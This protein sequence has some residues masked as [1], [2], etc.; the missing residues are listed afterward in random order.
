MGNN[1]SNAWYVLY[2]NPTRVISLANISD[3][4]GG[5]QSGAQIN[6]VDINTDSILMIRQSDVAHTNYRNAVAG[7]DLGKYIQTGTSDAIGWSEN[8]TYAM[9]VWGEF[10][11]MRGKTFPL[12]NML[13]HRLVGATSCVSTC[14]GQKNISGKHWDLE[15]TNLGGY[16]GLPPGTQ[17]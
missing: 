8:Y 5:S 6:V 15:V 17:Q 7:I 10:G 4:I 13:P 9:T 1:Y 14:N 12:A 16:S 11:I 3:P 2:D